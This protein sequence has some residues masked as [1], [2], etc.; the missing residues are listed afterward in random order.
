MSA[1]FVSVPL[2]T[3]VVKLHNRMVAHHS[4]HTVAAPTSPTRLAS[5]LTLVLGVAEKARAQNV[6]DALCTGKCTTVHD[7]PLAAPITLLSQHMLDIQRGV[8]TPASLLQLRDKLFQEPCQPT[9][10]PHHALDKIRWA[11]RS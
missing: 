6:A 5:R 8:G 9:T 1:G 10:L 3:R 11:L 4:P 2:P 7:D